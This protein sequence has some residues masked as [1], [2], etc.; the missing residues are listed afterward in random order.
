MKKLSLFLCLS[1]ALIWG[2]NDDDEGDFSDVV[3]I[4][5]SVLVQNEFQQPLYDERD[6]VSVDLK[7]G[8]QD[9]GLAADAIG[10]YQLSGAPV[11]TYTGT[12]SKAGCGT[13][14]S[15][16][17][18]VSDTNPEF[19]VYNGAQRLPTVTLTKLPV[20]SFENVEMDLQITEV[21]DGTGMVIDTV[22]NLTVTGTMNPPPPPTGQSKGYR[23]FMGTDDMVSKSNFIDQRFYAS[24]DADFVIE[25]PDEWFNEFGVTSGDVLGCALYGDANFDYNDTDPSTGLPVFPNTSLSVGAIQSIALP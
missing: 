1:C 10:K 25:F 17:L 4:E 22:Y 18:K 6:G 2:C 21:T 9:F 23:I 11:G 20:T 5:G 12:Y 7:V 3:V 16:N 8:F 14:Y 13:V 24:T 19:P 15:K